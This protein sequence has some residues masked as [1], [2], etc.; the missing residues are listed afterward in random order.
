MFTQY[1]AIEI[2]TLPQEL[3]DVLKSD[4]RLLAERTTSL[5]VQSCNDCGMQVEERIALNQHAR[6]TAFRVTQDRSVC[7]VREYLDP[8]SSHG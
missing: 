5:F 6:E 3:A 4:T 1:L 7:L 8:F 2:K